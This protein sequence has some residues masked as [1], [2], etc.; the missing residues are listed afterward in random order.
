MVFEQFTPE[1][2]LNVT[3]EVDGWTETIHLPDAGR[4]SIDIC[5]PPPFVTTSTSLEVN[6]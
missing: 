4:Y 5:P 1:A 3:T 6:A 2:L